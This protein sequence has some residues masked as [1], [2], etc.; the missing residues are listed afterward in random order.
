MTKIS[1]SVKIS[2]F[3]LATAMIFIGTMA[4][5]GYNSVFNSLYKEAGENNAITARLL[6]ESISKA[7]SVAA[8]TDSRDACVRKGVLSVT[9]A[10]KVD[11]S[12][13]GPIIGNVVFDDA[14]KAWAL[15]FIVPEKNA[16]G[17]VAGAYKVL[18]DICSLFD[19]FKIGNTGVAALVDDRAY[20]VYYPGAKIFANKFCEY[21]ELQGV[22]A[23]RS[24]WSRMDTAYLHDKGA[25]ASFAAV[26]N[27]AFSKSGMKW[28]VFVVQDSA[29]VLAPARTFLRN[30]LLLGVM[31]ILLTAA[32]GFIFGRI[33]IKPMEAVVEGVEHL[34]AGDLNFRV[35]PMHTGDE[36]DTFVDSFD[37]MADKVKDLVQET[38]KEKTELEKKERELEGLECMKT[39]FTNTLRK[40]SGSAGMLKRDM[41]AL[42]EEKQF[43]LD[44]K[45]KDRLVVMSESIAALSNIIDNIVD[46]ARIDTGKMELD[47]KSVDVKDMF[48]PVIFA[49]EPKI[50][51][52]GLLLKTSLPK[53]RVSVYVDQDRIG[54]VLN[55]LIDNAMKF[56]D[57]GTVG[58]DVK[59][60]GTD[61]EVIVSDTGR[62]IPASNITGIFERSSYL[63]PGISSG[64][65][66]SSFNLVIAKE[67]VKLHGGNMWA[68]SDPGKLTRIFFLL[69]KGN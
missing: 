29:E 12:S 5:S 38:S 42:L 56:T 52:K 60:R 41:K 69:P 68:E 3:A 25:I 18:M 30:M 46:I 1:V 32:I 35:K 43:A 13:A 65:V 67:I 10:D 19:D 20:L 49:F 31:I 51:E 48:R 47:R 11:V 8:E 39:D 17:E 44:T 33:F 28:R 27:S 36:L 9:P 26:E 2:I 37:R 54:K 57:K 15:P 62:G 21:N 61:I 7:I 24:G 45:S 4:F 23:S 16:A 22:L 40:L 53:E 34:E 66:G 64:I 58:I 50:R 63:M 14:S 6:A 55:T 59:D